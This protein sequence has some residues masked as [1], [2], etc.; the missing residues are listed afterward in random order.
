MQI[1]KQTDAVPGFVISHFGLY[2]TDAN[3]QDL[4][5]QPVDRVTAGFSKIKLIF[6]KFFRL[7]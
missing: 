3:G 6:A 4:T 7:R 2:Q 5:N 1:K